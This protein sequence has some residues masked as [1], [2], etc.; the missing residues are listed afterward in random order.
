MPVSTI[1]TRAQARGAD[2]EK[3]RRLI[4]DVPLVVGIDYVQR[5]LPPPAQGV[6]EILPV[7]GRIQF[8]EPQPARRRVV[9]RPF[10]SQHAMFMWQERSNHRTVLRSFEIER[11]VHAAAH[12]DMLADM[13]GLAPSVVRPILALGVRLFHVDVLNISI[14][15]GEAPGDVCIVPGDD[16]RNSRRG[17]AG[18]VEAARVQILFVPDVR[19][20]VVKMHVVG[21]Q[22]LAAG[23]ARAADN[24]LIRAWPAERT[25]GQSQQPAQIQKVVSARRGIGRT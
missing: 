20:A 6:A 14:E 16:Q 15:A 3:P 13:F 18:N 8:L 22:R 25:V 10:Q 5:R 12:A 21:E 24:P 9:Q 19:D 23:G 7:V 17:D 4:A 1:G 2:G 11:Y